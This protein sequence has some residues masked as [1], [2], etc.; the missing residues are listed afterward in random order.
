MD[1]RG[2]WWRYLD[3]R[4]F[5]PILAVGGGLHYYPTS[6]YLSDLVRGGLSEALMI[7]AVLG[8]TVDRI[9]KDKLLGD[10]SSDIWHQLMGRDLPPEVKDFIKHA[11]LETKLVC[12]RLEL[13]YRLEERSDGRLD[14]I[15]HKTRE[16]EN[17]GTT[18]VKDWEGYTTI[19]DDYTPKFLACV[20]EMPGGQGFSWP[21]EEAAVR[22]EQ[23]ESALTAHPKRIT[24]APHGHK[25]SKATFSWKYSMIMR[26]TDTDINAY[27]IPSVGMTIV[28]DGKPDSIHFKVDNVPEPTGHIWRCND[29]LWA[30]QFRRLR[31]FDQSAG[32]EA[33]SPTS[34]AV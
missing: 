3:W 26:R 4:L 33:S 28:L 9:A 17:F 21:D 22:L 2:P 31:W 14:V 18:A 13:R 12:T 11:L 20:C 1:A 16:I 34:P 30:G 6:W 27:G 7:A 23:K 24:F 5:V 8:L 15:V 10:V 29:V 32:G 25:G 19:F